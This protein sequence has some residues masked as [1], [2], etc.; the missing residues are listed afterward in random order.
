MGGGAVHVS[1]C[2]AATLS[3]M[4]APVPLRRRPR[5]WRSS[6]PLSSHR[7]RHLLVALFLTFLEIHVQV[8]PAHG[9]WSADPVEVHATSDLCPQVSVGD[10]GQNG[11]IVIWQENTASGGLLK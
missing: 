1:R 5:S 6:L 10:D 7:S 4:L 9:A 3:D 2:S 11:A 8:R